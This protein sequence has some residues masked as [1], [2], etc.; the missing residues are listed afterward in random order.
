MADSITYGGVELAIIG[1]KEISRVHQYTPQDRAIY[2][3]TLWTFNV[4]TKV[5]PQTISFLA[6]AFQ[7]GGG[8]PLRQP[9]QT[10]VV[11]DQFL[12]AYLAR[13]RMTLTFTQNG[14]VR[15]TC[16]AVGMATDV[17]NGPVAEVF[18]IVHDIGNHTWIVDIKITARV[19]ECPRDPGPVLISNRWSRTMDTDGDY[20][21]YIATQGECIFD[22][23]L[24]EESNTWVDQYR[25]D[26]F[27]P[28]P[29]NCKRS[30][31]NVVAMPDGFTY[32]YS[33][34]DQ[35][36]FFNVKDA[37][38]VE[39]YH[40]EF[41]S[42]V[43][44][45]SATVQGVMNFGGGN[46]PGAAFNATIAALPKFYSNIICKVRGHRSQFKNSLLNIALGMAFE[47][48]PIGRLGNV[49]FI[50][51]MDRAGKNV[52]VQLTTRT[53][54]E[55]MLENN[56]GGIGGFLL[57][58]FPAT[59]A[60]LSVPAGWIAGGPP[61]PPPPGGPA[62]AL[63]AAM[64]PGLAVALNHIAQ[65]ENSQGNFYT[66]QPT[67]PNLAPPNSGGT[68]GTLLQKIITATLHGVCQTPPQADQSIVIGPGGNVVGPGENVDV[69]T[70]PNAPLGQPNPG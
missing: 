4:R 57:T 5:N 36:T 43:S 23:S 3:H 34:I 63:Q 58:N 2:L 19:R 20:L 8:N 29:T 13:P 40:T 70:Y 1:E 41:Y 32:R 56:I 18:N 25:L 52:E 39:C 54:P 47:R 28:I 66:Q 11:T 27:Q 31:I 24:L 51:G 67:I 14:V 69:R 35:E 49:E 59:S 30:N 10:P 9:G 62:A 65:V 48:I 21:S 17:A 7:L 68:R 45:Y 64:P 60:I 33:F 46:V 16:P 22:N 44:E 53:G 12:A 55:I 50:V 61:P 26:L 42:K 37:T 38:H 6:N 15:L